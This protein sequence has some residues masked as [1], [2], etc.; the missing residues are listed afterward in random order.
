M[1][2]PLAL[3][4]ILKSLG[5]ARESLQ[6]LFS[7]STNTT[8]FSQPGEFEGSPSRLLETQPRK[9]LASSFMKALE[10]M[11]RKDGEREE[12]M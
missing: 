4:S 1:E 3:V 5:P 2:T 11:E 9:H 6:V 7:P 12:K 10:E 8:L